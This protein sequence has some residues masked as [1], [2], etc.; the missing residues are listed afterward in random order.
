MANLYSFRR[1]LSPAVAAATVA[2]TGQPG[3][4]QMEEVMVTAQKRSESLQETPIAITAMGTAELQARGITDFRDIAMASPSLTQSPYPS[5]DMLILYMRGQGVA[6]PMEITADGSVGLYVDGFYIARP[7]GALFDLADLERVEV[8][9]GP[10]GTLYG[11]N[12]TGGAVNLISRKPTGEFGF[13]QTLSFGNRA[14]FRSLTSI[15]LPEFGGLSSKITL[16]KSSRDGYVK[17]LG[18]SHDYGEEEQTAGRLALNWRISD[19]FTA[20]YFLETGT[21][22]S[23]PVYY[24]GTVQLYPGYPDASSPTDTTHRPIDLEPSDSEFQGHGLTLTWDTS[25]TLSIKSLTGYRELQFD[26]FQDYAEGFGL[27]SRSFDQLSNYQFSQELQFIGEL[28]SAGIRY[29]AGLYYFR[30]TGSHYQNYY[31]D[32]SAIGFGI[33]E[34]FRWVDAEAESKAAYAQVTWTPSILDNRLDLTLGA[35]YTEDERKAERDFIVTNTLAGTTSELGEVN[36]QNFSQFDPSFTANYSWN[37]DLSTYAKVAT[38]Y[39]A[40]GSSEGAPMGDFNLT[41]DPEEITTY[42]IGLKS[43]W[44]DRRIRLNTAVFHS[45]FE[46]MQLFFVTDPRDTSIV[47]GYNAGDATVS[48]GEIEL[49]VAPTGDFSVK[50]DYTY[51]DP[52]FKEVEAL[53]G[54]IFDPGVNPASPYQ[55]GDNIKDLFVL[56]YAPRHSANLAVDYTLLRFATGDLSLNMNYNWQSKVYH[57]SPAG[58]GVP[59]RDRAAVSSYGLLDARL[60]LAVDLPRGDRATVALWGKNITDKEYVQQTIGLGGYVDTATAAAGLN[61]GA[62]AW[63]YRACLFFFIR[64]LSLNPAPLG[65]ISAGPASGSFA[66][67]TP[68]FNVEACCLSQVD[69]A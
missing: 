8:L 33:T 47:Q 1:Y 31:L 29:V 36:D 13:R 12:T 40:G 30:E 50:L 55:L 32:T 17:N 58:P 57:T 54:T 61:T 59:G 53:P 64:Y 20:E 4:A 18:S 37:D 65:V 10:Q 41:F 51:L 63:L 9:R 49:L 3:W 22:E 14:H 48:G 11:R 67:S 45:E 25:D 21:L 69:I 2:L 19:R 42:E 28:P 35:R 66:V 27:P 44:W 60:T 7:Q 23:T 15:D 24:Q 46:Q 26:G 39:K 43:Y 62:V 52:T 56:P 5:S 68:G 6:N 34:K 38:G 16:L